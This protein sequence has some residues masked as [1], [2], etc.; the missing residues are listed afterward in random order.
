MA[1][2]KT[3]IALTAAAGS[4]AGALIN[5]YCYITVD[6]YTDKQAI[7]EGAVEE[8]EVFIDEVHPYTEEDIRLLNE[9]YGKDLR[10]I[11]A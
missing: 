7:I 10:K 4:A 1:D 5:E 2:T 11:S 9:K 3:I 8:M 6:V